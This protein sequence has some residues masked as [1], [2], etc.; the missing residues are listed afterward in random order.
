MNND[1]GKFTAGRSHDTNKTS[2]RFRHWWSGCNI[3]WLRVV[4]IFGGWMHR[5]EIF[6]AP[7]VNEYETWCLRY[8]HPILLIPL[9]NQR[10]E[11]EISFFTWINQTA[12]SFQ[13]QLSELEQRVIE[14]E[15]RAEEAEDKVSK[16]YI[17]NGQID[18]RDSRRNAQIEIP[19]MEWVDGA[20][21]RKRKISKSQC[22]ETAD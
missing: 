17:K 14:A 3:H 11:E 9:L 13:L 22:T 20:S 12:F 2:L 18:A 15:G 8:F 4:Y 19:N 6:T 7:G 10:Y 21:A 16:C 1:C 5:W